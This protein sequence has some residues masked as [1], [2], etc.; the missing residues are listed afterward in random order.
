MY[1]DDTEILARN[2]NPNYIQLA[3]NRHIKALEDWFVKW[4]IATW[5]PHFLYVRQKC[6]AQARKLYLLIDRKS[7]MDREAN[8]LIYTA[9][10][11]PVITYACPTWEYAAKTNKNS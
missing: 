6:W 11:R 2:N 4:K 8:L 3:F 7:K 9:Y 10:L 1:A 5:K